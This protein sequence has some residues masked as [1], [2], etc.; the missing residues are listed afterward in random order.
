MLMGYVFI[1]LG[2]GVLPLCLDNSML[3]QNLWHS[4]N[5]SLF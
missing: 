4:H 5:L 2:T 3:A 1:T